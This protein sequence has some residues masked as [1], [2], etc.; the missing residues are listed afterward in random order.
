MPLEPHPSSKRDRTGEPLDATDEAP[1]MASIL[2]ANSFHSHSALTCFSCVDPEP[3]VRTAHYLDLARQGGLSEL[4]PHL[5]QHYAQHKTHDER[6][7]VVESLC[8]WMASL[9][10]LWAGFADPITGKALPWWQA[11]AWAAAHQA[12]T[13]QHCFLDA[14]EV[15][16]QR[17]AP[18]APHTGSSPTPLGAT[19]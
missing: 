5:S 15:Y 8:S 3:N 18:Q 11:R 1:P 13:A 19:S 7:E 10:K 2:G 4:R 16:R 9:M 6:R 12:E 14:P 17:H